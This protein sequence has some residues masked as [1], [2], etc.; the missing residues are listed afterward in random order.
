ML[1]AIAEYEKSM[2]VAKLRGG[3][4]R[5]SYL[6]GGNIVYTTSR[7][8]GST[9]VMQVVENCYEEFRDREQE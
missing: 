2:L 7:E 6:T 1:D 8:A 4:M 9:A 3:R 5:K